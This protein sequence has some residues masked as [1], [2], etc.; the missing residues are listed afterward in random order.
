MFKQ[1]MA[2]TLAA[3]LALAAPLA[4]AQAAYP[5]KPIRLVVPFAPGG[6]ADVVGRLIA[7]ELRAGLGQPVVVDNRP[8]AGGNIAGDMVAKSPADGYTLLLAAAGP[9]AINPS[10]YGR[11]PYNPAT[12]LAPVA[13]LARDHQLMAVT[14]SV[15]ARDVREFI[16]YA[17]VN[18]G[19]VSFGSPGNGT[20]AHL[21]GELFNQMAGTQMVHVPYKG[22]APAMN[23]LISG[24]ITVMI[25]NMPALLPQ[26]QSGRLRALG[27]ASPSRA[28]GAPDIPT[29][30]ESGL[31]GFNVTAWK[32]LM[33]P[34]GTPRPI[35]AKLNEVAVAAVA[36][37]EIRKRLVD[38]GAEPGGGS[39]EDFGALIAKD[40][41][42]WAALV[43][44]TGARVD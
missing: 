13:L 9:I 28:S 42:S 24:Q 8:G 17:K 19:K 14:P 32:G 1:L 33:A 44:S 30:A 6:S 43:K 29:V 5:T 36:K 20:P 27:V 25:D 11:M 15:P 31:P 26:V 39:P 2:A 10:L 41:R 18:P 23:D 16:A 38:L 7:E 40:S 37:P 34:A 12:D 22:S 4:S 21:G 3:G 35:V